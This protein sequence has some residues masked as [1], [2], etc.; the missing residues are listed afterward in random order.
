MKRGSDPSLNIILRKEFLTFEKMVIVI[1]RFKFSRLSFLY[2]KTIRLPI[3][4]VNISR[5]ELAVHIAYK[6]KC[7]QMTYQ[8]SKGGLVCNIG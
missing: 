7:Y 6:Q 4:T 8:V 1:H 3:I 5:S 2:I